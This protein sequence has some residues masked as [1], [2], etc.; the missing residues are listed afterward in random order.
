MRAVAQTDDSKGVMRSNRNE[1]SVTE[2]ESSLSFR[3]RLRFRCNE[4]WP[5]RL[6]YTFAVKPTLSA[7]LANYNSTKHCFAYFGLSPGG[8]PDKTKACLH[9]YRLPQNRAS[10]NCWTA[11]GSSCES[12]TTV[13]APKK[14]TSAGFAATFFSTAN[15]TPASSTR[16]TFRIF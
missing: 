13:C 16:K 4:G 11:S 12:G 3:T 14:R 5:K 2:V 10:R 8:A 9:L 6:H 7:V 1:F 15:D